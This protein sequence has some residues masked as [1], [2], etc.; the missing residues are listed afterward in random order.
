MQTVT[1]S[2]PIFFKNNEYCLAVVIGVIQWEVG[3]HSHQFVNVNSR[4]YCACF[5][6]H[7]YVLIMF[8][9]GEKDE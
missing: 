7:R 8:Y 3:L 1:R 2:K 5:I 9:N 4:L 6:N